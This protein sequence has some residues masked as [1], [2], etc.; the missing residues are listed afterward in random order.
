MKVMFYSAVPR[1]DKLQM[2]DGIR[3]VIARQKTGAVLEVHH[4]LKG[5]IAA[6]SRSIGEPRPVAI[7][8]I[9]RQEEFQELYRVRELFIDIPL[10]LAQEKNAPE[11][12]NL[13]H[14]LGPR[15][16]CKAPCDVEVLKQVLAS[17]LTRPAHKQ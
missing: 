14:H 17:L 1:P 10:L 8:N 3:Q 5:M 13:I 16:I 11:L 6:L 9:T 12:I 2:L 7:I 15:F 4:Q